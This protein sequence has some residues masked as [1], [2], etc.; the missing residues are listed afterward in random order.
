MEYMKSIIVLGMH[1]SATSMVSRSL[2]KSNEV[3]MGKDLLLGHPDNPRGHYEDISFLHLNIAILNAAGGD[4]RS[5]PSRKN[6][7][8]VAP[9]F[10]KRIKETI[11]NAV[12]NAKASG[13]QSWGFKD[14]RTTLTIELYTPFLTNPQFICCFRD[15]NE[16]AKSLNK[17]DNITIKE[18]VK[19]TSIYNQRMFDFLKTYYSC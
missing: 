13:C 16:I 12:N 3:Y 15:P 6:I 1:R 17:R 9:K 11:D 7:L 4:W 18:G 19:M 14:P 10:N 8:D 2:H 5:A